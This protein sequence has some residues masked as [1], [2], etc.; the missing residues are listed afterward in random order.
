MS[1]QQYPDVLIVGAGFS[2]VYQ[3]HKLRKAGFTVELFEAGSGLGGIWY[4]NRYPGARV[5][6][7]FSIYQLSLEELW[8]DWNW[9]EKFPGRQELVE[10]FNYVDKKLGLS[11]DIS[12]NTR[13]TSAFFDTTTNRWSVSTD[14]KKMINPQF[15]ILCTGFAAKPLFPDVPG[16]DTFEGVVHHTSSWPET[17]FDMTGKRVGVIGTGASGVQLIQ[18]AGP[19]VTH[20][21]VFQRTPNLAVPMMNQRPLSLVMQAKMKEEMYPILFKR[22]EQTFTGFHYDI[23]PRGMFELSAEERYLLCDD[24]WSKGGFRYVFGSC[25][26]ILTDEKAN[27]E[28]YSFWRKKV[29]ERVRDPEMQRKLAPEKQ[30]HPFGTKRISLEQSYYEVFNQPNVDLVDLNENTIVGITSKGVKTQDGVVHE[31]DVLVLATGFDAVTGSISQID[32]K[33]MDG[34]NIGEKWKKGLSTYLGMT[35]SGYPNMFFPYGPQA[36]TAFCNGPTCAEIQGNWIVDCLVYLRRH[37]FARIDATQEASKA[38][39]QRIAD[40]FSQGLWDRAKSWYTGANVPGKRIEPLNFTGGLPLY[41]SLIQGSAQA[42]YAGFTLT[43]GEGI[44]ARL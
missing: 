30:P 39:V 8:K 3:L 31:L 6:S 44:K 28:V 11:R 13:V 26:D 37:N 16:L 25:K 24:L 10:Y 17:G 29:L 18:E 41:I 5:D 7:D 34:I 40:I 12:F 15:L 1:G 36:P 21:T 42:G 23:L 35:V 33:G 9:E 2:G 27:A 22:R 43:P 32:I 38:W 4:W 19:I 14:T 20:L